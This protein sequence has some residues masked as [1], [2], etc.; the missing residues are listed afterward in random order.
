MIH[1]TIII[2]IIIINQ[3]YKYYNYKY[4][5]FIL[6]KIIFKKK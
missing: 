6:I 4:K 1:D 2:I 3:Y 5:E